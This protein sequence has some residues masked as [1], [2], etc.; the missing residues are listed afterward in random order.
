MVWEKRRG[1]G[2]GGEGELNQINGVVNKKDPNA[3]SIF[4][5]SEKKTQKKAKTQGIKYGMSMT[6]LQ[7]LLLKTIGTLFFGCYSLFRSVST[8]KNQI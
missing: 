2:R 4:M 1:E 3:H 6:W 7:T 8:E 5:T